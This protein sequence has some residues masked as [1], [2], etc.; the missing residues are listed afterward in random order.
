MAHISQRA[1]NPTREWGAIAT[2]GWCDGWYAAGQAA[3]KLKPPW[4]DGTTHL[5][6][7]PLE[8]T[9]R[10]AALAPLRPGSRS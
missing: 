8:L 2:H 7:L 6:M 5:A 1:A 9:Q 10:L 4:R 3:L